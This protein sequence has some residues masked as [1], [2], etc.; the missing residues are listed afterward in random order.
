MADI[1]LD[2]DKTSPNYKDLLIVNNDLVLTS[3][4][5]PN[6]TNPILQ[7]LIQR[8]SFGLGEWFMDNTQGVPWIQQILV[9][10]PD[11]GKIDAIFVRII[12]GTPGV[13]QLS[14]YSFNLNRVAR[15]LKVQ[16][17]CVTTKGV[18]NYNGNV[19]VAA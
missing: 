8:I 12:L 6:G 11:Q 13:I 17:S 7:N 18:V 2:L 14:S 15:V 16:F 3:D 10:N 19:P 1:S 5:D 9:K 4:A